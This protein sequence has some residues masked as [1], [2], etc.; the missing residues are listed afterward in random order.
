MDRRNEVEARFA[1]E[2][3]E[4]TVEFRGSEKFVTEQMEHVRE[5][6]HAILASEN[7]PPAESASPARSG[8]PSGSE[9]GRGE[10]PTLESIY[11]KAKTR[12]GR[13]ALQDSVIIFAHY[14]QAYQNKLEFSIE[15]LNFCFDLL[16]IRRPKSLAN[17][18]GIIKR[19]RKLLHSGGK[20][21]TYTLSERGKEKVRRLVP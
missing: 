14:M 20:R 12:E 18:L 9:S 15:D 3:P 6:V 5:R 17:T 8:S 7:G 21:G 19:D 4:F 16:N 13:G 11:L 2:S 10:K 1:F